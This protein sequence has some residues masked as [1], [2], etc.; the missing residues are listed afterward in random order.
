MARICQEVCQG[1]GLGQ[2]QEYKIEFVI[3]YVFVMIVGFF[4]QIFPHEYRRALEEAKAEDIAKAAQAVKA[5]AAAAAKTNGHV[6]GV[7]GENGEKALNEDLDNEFKEDAITIEA[8][9]QPMDKVSSAS[10]CNAKLH[11]HKMS[12]QFLIFAISMF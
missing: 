3:L 7:N 6:N 2:L 1:N 12:T 4:S 5:E 11:L 8:I 9:N 10:L